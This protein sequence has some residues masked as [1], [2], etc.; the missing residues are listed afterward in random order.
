MNTVPY[1]ARGTSYTWI[2]NLIISGL[3]SKW[4]SCNHEFLKHKNFSQVWLKKSYDFKKK[5]RER[6]WEG[7]DAA[8]LEDGRSGAQM[9][10]YGQPVWE[11]SGNL[12]I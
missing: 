11:T 9:K 3:S 12:K 10:E 7:F 5:K 8:D 4:N 2:S 6:E 1:M